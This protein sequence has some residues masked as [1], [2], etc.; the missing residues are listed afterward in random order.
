M[1][2]F[3]KAQQVTN[4]LFIMYLHLLLVN[5]FVLLSKP[6]AMTDKLRV[7]L[8]TANNPCDWHAIDVK[9]H[10]KC[11]LKHVINAATTTGNQRASTIAAQI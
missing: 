2:F 11:W 3:V 1:L 9:Y 4:N 6:L 10:K 5:H 7:K 8:S